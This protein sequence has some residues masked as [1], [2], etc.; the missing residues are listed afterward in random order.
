MGEGLL[1]IL[2][3]VRRECMR[4][5]GFTTEVAMDRVLILRRE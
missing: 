1:D 4:E 3:G 2:E 5:E